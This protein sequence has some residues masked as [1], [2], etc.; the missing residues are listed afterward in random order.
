MKITDNIKKRVSDSK[1]EQ[2]HILMPAD[3]NGVYRLFGGILMQWIDVVA[4]VVARRH[5]GCNVTT[6]SVDSLQFLAPAHINDTVTLLGKITYVGRSSM[7]V[8]VE[9][10]VE[11]LTG[12]RKLVNR[13]YMVMVA[14]DEHERPC[15]AP[16]LIIETDEERQEWE[17]AKARFEARKK[18]RQV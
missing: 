14:V 9:T 3:S 15:P 5:S 10:F 13:A 11:E 4:G 18:N 2:V 17:K 7:E 12:E 6:A 16:G 8:C 1:T